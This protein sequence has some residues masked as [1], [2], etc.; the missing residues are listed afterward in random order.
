MRHPQ[1][2]RYS[3][4]GTTW[5]GLICGWLLTVAGCLAFS[6]LLMASAQAGSHRLALDGRIHTLSSP[7]SRMGSKHTQ[8]L[9]AMVAPLQLSERR[10]NYGAGVVAS[11]QP[12][13]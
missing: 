8:R 4:L 12:A 6:A 1:N 13:P 11:T 9:T 10:Q 2:S 7:I 3:Q 5:A